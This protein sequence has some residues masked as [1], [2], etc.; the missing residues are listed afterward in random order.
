MWRN[1][2]SAR[3]LREIL[4]DVALRMETECIRQDLSNLGIIFIYRR[5]PRSAA[6]DIQ[7]APNHIMRIEPVDRSQN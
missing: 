1:E 2:V 3:Q 6:F 5:S 4:P 7:M